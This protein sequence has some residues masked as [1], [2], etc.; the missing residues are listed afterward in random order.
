MKS[1]PC[2]RHYGGGKRAHHAD[3]IMELMERSHTYE[4]Q[5]GPQPTVSECEEGCDGR[6]AGCDRAQ[7]RCH[8]E[9]GDTFKKI[10]SN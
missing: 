8:G 3:V 4:R 7:W 9:T 5:S 2:V 1:L 10:N 6:G